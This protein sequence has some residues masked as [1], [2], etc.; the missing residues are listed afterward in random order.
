MST[1]AKLT[2]YYAPNACS[3]V[4]HA[5]L[6]QVGTPFDLVQ[7]A[8]KPRP[9]GLWDL[10]A[11][12]GSF[13]NDEY[14]K[15][16][17]HSK[18]PGLRIPISSTTGEASCSL[19]TG[20]NDVGPQQL[21]GK[22]ALSLDDAT[23]LTE[24]PAIADFIAGMTPAGVQLLGGPAGS[25]GRARV[26]EW[27]MWLVGS[28]QGTHWASLRSGIAEVRTQGAEGSRAAYERINQLLQGREFAVG[29]SLTIADL[30]LYSWYRIGTMFYRI[31]DGEKDW[32]AY[33][34]HAK[35]MEGL[36]AVRATLQ[37]EG[38]TPIAA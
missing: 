27:V 4:V 32:P 19:N 23:F 5:L 25:L 8:F 17:P 21:T 22:A 24:L 20:D 36:A 31:G 30:V 35:K 12:D 26:L 34:A 7:L 14:R 9:D 2:L 6:R 1:S 33:A 13:A 28:V 29:D 10:N 38:Q 18:V 15:L 16:H 3:F 37:A 11:A